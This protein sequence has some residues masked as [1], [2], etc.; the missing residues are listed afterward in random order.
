[1]SHQL[2]T[3]SNKTK[4][5]KKNSGKPVKANKDEIFSKDD[6]IGLAWLACFIAQVSE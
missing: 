5:K 6:M 4:K 2:V 3:I 1:M